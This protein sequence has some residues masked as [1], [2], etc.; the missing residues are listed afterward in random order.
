MNKKGILLTERDKTETK[1][2]KGS[3]KI[4]RLLTQK[5]KST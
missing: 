4:S 2:E 3:T 1:G 5:E